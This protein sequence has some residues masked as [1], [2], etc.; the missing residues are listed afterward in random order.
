MEHTENYQ[1]SQWAESDRILRTDFNSDNAKIEAA[2]AEHDQL[3]ENLGGCR[4]ERGSYVGTGEAGEEHPNSLTLSGTPIAL[5]IYGP[6]FPAILTPRGGVTF[7][8]SSNQHL[9]TS[10]S[11]NTISWYHGI[12]VGY[13]QNDSGKTYYYLALVEAA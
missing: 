2:L 1:L 13:Q 8:S 3:L 6:G 11:R 10:V 7:V 12:T 5:L 9:T 4:I